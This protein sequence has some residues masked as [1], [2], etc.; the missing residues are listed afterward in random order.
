[1]QK[2]TAGQK[3]TVFAFQD[4]GGASPGEPVTGDAANITASV[5]IDGAAA[6]AVDDTNPTEVA[7][8]YY[9][10]DITAA[11]SNGEQIVIVAASS[12]ANVNVIGVPGVVYTT[13]ASFPDDV[14]QT[15]D[16]FARLGAPTGADVST[17]IATLQSSL[18]GLT[19]TGAAVNVGARAAPNGFVLT[20]GSE[21]ND[22][23]STQ[24]L[25][26]TRH[27]LTD[28]AGT[29]DG[30]YKFD[31]GGD[32]VPT[33]VTIT[34][35]FNGSNDSWTI[36]ANA[37]TTGTPTWQQIGTIAGTNGTAN[38]SHTF[39]MLVGQV[40]TDVSGEVQIR[41]NG[42]GLTTSSFDVDQIIVSKDVVNKS[43]GYAMGAVWID[44][45]T[46]TA[47]TENYV[48]GV[49]DNPVDTLADALT[50]ATALGLRRFEVANGTTLTLAATTANKVF[51]GHEWTLALGG[52]NVASTMVIDATVSG[53]GTG[54]DAEFQDCIFGITSLPAMQAYDC[55]FTATTSGGFTMSAAGQ[56]RFINC[57]SGVPGSGSPLFTLGTG[58]MNVEFR[59][60]SGGIAF[61]GITADDVL[62]ISGELGTVDLGAPSGA[63][64]VQIRGTY[65]AITNVG[66]AVVNTDGAIKGMDVASILEDT[67]TTLPA[68]IAGLN[69]ITVAEIIAGISDG[70]FDFQEIIRIIFAAVAGK[71]SGHESGTPN[72]RDSADSKNRIAATTDANGNRTAVTL[73]GS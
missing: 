2:N 45:N 27:E 64:D 51:D 62:T 28:A 50:I 9:T 15:G 72:Y 73:D 17:D 12:T 6:N 47:G 24:A 25:D 49:A 32:G 4:Q 23:D 55:S 54:A 71:S 43:V 58:A 65:K 44:A 26:G 61:A 33:S 35:V 41:I 37:G 40:V 46:G 52:Q 18:D 7:G 69:D 31:I 29:L 21:V 70:S 16:S 56:Y 5:Y 68:Q 39:Q 53:T 34:G 22:E 59:R 14:V 67:G 60:W 63:A 20:T 13:P 1:M 66:S 36:S 38:V 11:E 8:G 57:Q 30:L 3:W 42:T 19:V 10:F 48:N